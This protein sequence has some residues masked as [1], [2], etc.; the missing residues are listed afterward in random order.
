[1]FNMGAIM[2]GTAPLIP[3]HAYM[4]RFWPEY[5]PS[6]QTQWRF[7]LVDPGSGKRQGFASLE[8]LVEFLSQLTRDDASL[9]A[10]PRPA[11]DQS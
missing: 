5:P 9:S 11:E 10:S 3:Y 4:L 2:P 1:M 6:G 8:A 7:T